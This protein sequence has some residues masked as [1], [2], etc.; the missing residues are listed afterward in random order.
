MTAGFVGL[1]NIGSP[2]AMRLATGRPG[3]VVYDVAPAACER[4]AEHAT[5]ATSPADL[6]RQCRLIAVC[7][8]DDGDVESV[9]G[10]PDGLLAGLEGKPGAV[11]AIHS[12]ISLDNLKRFAAMA[13]AVGAE[14]VDAAVTGGAEVAAQGKLTTMVGGSDGIAGRLEP[15]IGT[16][17]SRILHV[18]ELGAG[19]KLKVANNLVTYTQL[20]VGVE[21]MRLAAL[22][23]VD[24]AQ[25]LAVMEGNGNLTPAMA[26]YL[27]AR[28]K[29][30]AA[31][32]GKTL[33]PFQQGL[34]A[35]AE[36]DLDHALST[37]AAVGAP[38]LIGDNVRATF[39]QIIERVDT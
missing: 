13:A 23:G 36:K 26:A 30:I 24:P 14:L 31:G 10:G 27:G 17:S 25:L 4:F 34:A 6:S 18:G 39:R 21:A 20:G 3:S 29:A 28:H 37:A 15:M 38:T 19:M 35:L 12:T 5:I 16:Y 22:S 32:A 33:L 11:I 7:V 1:G 2:M 8:R 9:L